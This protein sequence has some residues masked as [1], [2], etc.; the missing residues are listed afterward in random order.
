MHAQT[1]DQLRKQLREKFPGAH[2]PRGN[3]TAAPLAGPLALSPRAF[4]KGAITEVVPARFRTGL[5]LLM[6]AMLE[7]EPGASSVPELALIDGRDQFDPTSFSPDHCAKLLWL[8]CQNP[9]QSI[10]AAD[11]I[12]RDGNLPRVVLDLLAFSPAELRDIPNSTWQRLKRWIESSAASLVTLS[13]YPLVP[14]ATLRLSMQSIFSLDHF[15]QTRGELIQQLKIT[16][17]LQRQSAF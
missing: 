17:L 8:R 3:T 11:L 13:P 9:Q 5:S 16:P 10:H 1:L 6:A 7:E 2:S 14:C 4:P 15:T 12:L